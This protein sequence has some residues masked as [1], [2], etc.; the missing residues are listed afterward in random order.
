[1]LNGA[2]QIPN[3]NPLPK[4]NPA[5]RPGPVKAAPTTAPKVEPNLTDQVTLSE[6]AQEARRLAA[7]AAAVPETRSNRVAEAKALLGAGGNAAAQN[8]KIAE[9]LLTEI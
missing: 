2:G 7:A 1:M 6:R 4:P 3:F 8:A 9:K 5:N